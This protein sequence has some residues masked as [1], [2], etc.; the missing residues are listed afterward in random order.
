MNEYELRNKKEIDEFVTKINEMRVNLENERQ[1][2]LDKL[3]LKY[4]RIKKQLESIQKSE[5]KR[6]K[7]FKN[8]KVAH[9]DEGVKKTT[10]HNHNLM[11]SKKKVLLKKIKNMN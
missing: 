3:M 1:K 6:L 5:N 2:E 4:E 11:Q 8:Y 9:M 7:N 10:S